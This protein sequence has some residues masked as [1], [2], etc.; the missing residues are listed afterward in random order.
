[1]TDMTSRV[2]DLHYGAEDGIWARTFGGK[3]KYDKDNAKVT[4]SFWGAQIGADKLQKNGWHVG[5]AFDYNKGD[6]KYD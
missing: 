4:N 3:V 2:G 5:G 1:M 6:A